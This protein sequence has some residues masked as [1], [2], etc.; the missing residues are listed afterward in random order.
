MITAQ[1]YA[2]IVALS[3][4]DVIEILPKIAGKG[5]PTQDSRHVFL[6]MLKTVE[7][8][9]FKS[10]GNAHLDI[11]SLPLLDVFIMMFLSAVSKIVKQGV[12]RS[13]E[14]IE[15]N[16]NFY[17]GRLLVSAN[18]AQNL[19]RRDRFF[20]RHDEFTLN[21]PENR[22]VKTTMRFVMGL[23]QSQRIQKQG[24]QLL[25]YFSGVEFSKNIGT[26]FQHCHGDRTMHGY[27]TVLCWCKV[28]LCGQSFT[29][30]SGE[31][32]ALSLLF[33][34]DK[35]FESYVARIAQRVL[36]PVALL[37][38]QDHRLSLF[39]QPCRSFILRPDLVVEW[40][41]GTAILDTKWKILAQSSRNH[42]IAE[43]DM[44]QMFAY[45]KKYNARSVT[46]LYPQSDWIDE[47]GLSYVGEDDVAIKVRAIDMME[48]RN[49]IKHILESSMSDPA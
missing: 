32:V 1:N 40:E 43:S 23:T 42:G 24:A 49:S 41:G 5:I 12:R 14:P 17:R 47:Q 20:L 26:D 16:Q 18:I 30:I 4:G 10:L 35:L 11:D 27:Q 7:T 9:K 48:A 31:N 3:T 21:V 19:W 46:L 44:Y 37:R 36:A 15:D 38:V 6:E 22:L 34:L 13:Y 2:G 33:P 45:A 8:E 28:I 39:T 25:T 29:P